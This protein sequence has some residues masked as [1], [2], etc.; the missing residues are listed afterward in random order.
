MIWYPL[1][2]NANETYL[3]WATYQEVFSFT[4]EDVNGLLDKAVPDDHDDRSEV[5]EK[6]NELIQQWYD[7]YYAYI[8]ICLY[9]PWSVICFLKQLQ[10]WLKS[11][12][13][14]TDTEGLGEI[15]QTYWIDMDSTVVLDKL[16]SL[17]DDSA[18]HTV[19]R[20]YQ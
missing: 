6:A 20:A 19:V 14:G 9:N 1:Y 16:Y 10:Y 3:G 7:G 11:N 18:R 15:A 13:S 2:T 12:P 8:D 4:K 5:I 17:M